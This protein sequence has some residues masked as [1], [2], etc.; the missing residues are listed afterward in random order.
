MNPPLLAVFTLIVLSS[1]SA[2]VTGLDTIFAKGGTCMYKIRKPYD[3][4]MESQKARLIRDRDALE[5]IY[6]HAAMIASTNRISCCAFWSFLDCV[7]EAAEEHCPGDR[8]DMEAYVAQLGSAVPVQ[9]C[10]EQF[11]RDSPMCEGLGRGGAGGGGH[12]LSSTLVLVTAL[13]GALVSLRP[14]L[15]LFLLV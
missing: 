4:C 1:L 6:T 9:D 5:P 10:I 3:A 13:F 12:F 14:H 2:V 7:Y 11:P 15:Q 8:R